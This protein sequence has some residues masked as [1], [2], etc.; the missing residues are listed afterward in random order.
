MADFIYYSYPLQGA[1]FL[2]TCRGRS[3]PG[4]I[5]FTHN[6]PHRPL[7]C[8]LRAEN[9]VGKWLLKSCTLSFPRLASGHQ[10]GHRRLPGLRLPPFLVPG[11]PVHRL[12]LWST[13]L[14]S[15]SPLGIPLPRPLGSTES[16]RR[17]ESNHLPTSGWR[18]HPGPHG[19]PRPWEKNEFGQPLYL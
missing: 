13:V 14:V 15:R 9:W 10:C 3:C 7:P 4:G 11:F 12:Q 6:S 18:R 17:A 5:N 2:P 19:A 1:S 16:Y 8:S